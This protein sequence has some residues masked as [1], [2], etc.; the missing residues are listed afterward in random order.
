MSSSVDIDNAGEYVLI[1]GTD[2]TQALDDSENSYSINFFK[3]KLS[4]HF[5][6]SNRFLFVNTTKIYQF[7]AKDSAIKEIS[8]VFRKYFRRF[9]S[10]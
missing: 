7:K 4:L 9:F 8:F 3:I 5:N 1:I 10:Q 6:R 2:T